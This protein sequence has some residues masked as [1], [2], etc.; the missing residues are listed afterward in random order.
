MR[1]VTRSAAGAVK[2]IVKVARRTIDLQHRV[3][4]L[5]QMVQ[6]L[7]DQLSQLRAG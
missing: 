3:H 4:A 6:G 7:R 2:R 1:L 5:E